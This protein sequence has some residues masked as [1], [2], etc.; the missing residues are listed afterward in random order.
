MKTVKTDKGEKQIVTTL[1]ELRN[2]IMVTDA[3]FDFRYSLS[4]KLRHI[5]LHRYL[6]ELVADMIQNTE[7]LP[8]QTSILD[9][10]EWSHKQTIK[11]DTKKYE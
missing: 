5:M 7:N 10:M 4:H 8:S 11:P 9:L 3:W 1:K 2:L 6:D